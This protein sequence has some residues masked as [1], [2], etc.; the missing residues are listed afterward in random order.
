MISPE[1]NKAIDDYVEAT[2][3][4]SRQCY[5]VLYPP[6]VV[7]S[8][9]VDQVEALLSTGKTEAEVIW[10]LKSLSDE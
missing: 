4:P 9:M 6:P 5:Q 2:K 3:N 8:G 1:L 7:R 10:L